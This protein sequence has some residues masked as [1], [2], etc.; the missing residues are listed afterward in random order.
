M[1]LILKPSRTIYF[2]QVC[3]HVIV[4]FLQLI[5][6][7]LGRIILNL[8]NYLN[9]SVFETYLSNNCL[10]NFLLNV[11]K[12]VFF[13]AIDLRFHVFFAL[14][15]RISLTKFSCFRLYSREIFVVKNFEL[16]SLWAMKLGKSLYYILCI[17]T[18]F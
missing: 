1:T 12:N 4:R 7:I 6:W 13:F 15:V 18:F 8:L 2:C 17:F 10:R 5:L 14:P 11:N 3:R 16:D 9:N